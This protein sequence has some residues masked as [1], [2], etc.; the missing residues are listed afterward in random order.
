MVEDP[1]ARNI[2]VLGLCVLFVWMAIIIFFSSPQLFRDLVRRY[3]CRCIKRS[4][5]HQNAIRI[6]LA[7]ER[8]RSA[9]KS[10]L[11]TSLLDQPSTILLHQ[12]LSTAYST[13]SHQ[14]RHEPIPEESRCTSQQPTVQDVVSLS[15]RSIDDTIRQLPP[16]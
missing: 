7:Q 14:T 16:V 1:E 6:K 3:C 10:F 5:R 11:T 2:F 12:V 15:E 8:V 9:S 4:D 13:A